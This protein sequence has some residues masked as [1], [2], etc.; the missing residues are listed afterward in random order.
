MHSSFQYL[1]LVLAYVFSLTFRALHA[2]ETSDDITRLQRLKE[3]VQTSGSGPAIAAIRSLPN[4]QRQKWLSPLYQCLPINQPNGGGAVPNYFELIQLIENTIDGGWQSA[5]GTSSMMPYSNGV[6]IDVNG[7]IERFDPSKSTASVVKFPSDDSKPSSIS[8]SG[9]GD[10]QESSPLRWVSLNMLDQQVADRME[11]NNAA[12]ASIAME[13]LGGLYRIDY[14]A[15]DSQSQDWLLGGPAGSLEIKKSGALVNLETGLPPVLLEDLLSIAPQV[16]SGNGLFGC[17]IDPDP[18]RL[19]EAYEMAR[20]PVAMRSLQRNPERWVEEWRKKLGRQN[21]KVIGLP[22]DSPTGYAMIVADAHMKR[23]GLEL[24]HRPTSMNSYWQEKQI[25]K[26][27]S[28]DSG[29]VRWWFSLTDHKIPM[30]PDRKI[31]RFASSNV[32]VLSEA[33]MLNTTGERVA[34]N[35]PDIAA[36]AFAKGFTQNFGKLQREYECYGRLRHIFD[37]AVALEIVRVEMEK[38]NGRPFLA[39]DDPK[40]QPRLAMAPRE[41]ESVAATYKESSGSVSAIVSGGVSIQLKS[42][43]KRMVVDRMQTHR[44]SIEASNDS[45]KSKNDNASVLRSPLSDEPFW[46]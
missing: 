23:M 14:V 35:A 11:P 45:L 10:W 30:D 5:G 13:L 42:L 6:R 32:Q 29:L 33:Q 1:V 40:V 34:A 21:T 24:E 31:Y 38:G 17:T 4:E 15:F 36:E 22:Q 12:R 43:Q 20:T 28:K 7:V 37:L 25:F 26:N 8:L 9:L 19:T 18:K 44:V 41:I 27:S 46:R 16:L 2:D 39:I 3:S